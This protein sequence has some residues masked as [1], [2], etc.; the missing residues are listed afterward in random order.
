M[1]RSI[2]RRSIS[3]DFSFVILLV[4]SVF[5]V[6]PSGSWSIGVSY[7][8]PESGIDDSKETRKERLN[9]IYPGTKWCGSGNVAENSE[10]LGHFPVT[11]ACCRDHDQC[12]DVIEAMGTRH[13]ITN[14]A[15][16]TRVECSCDEK[17]YDCLHHSDDKIAPQIGTFYFSLLNTQCFRRDYPIISCKRYSTYPRR[18]VE[19]D[20]DESQPKIHQWFDVPPY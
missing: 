4:L 14:S 18:C 6:K 13:N 2:M 17:F 20:L 8:E 5:D 1:K 12:D 19:Y 15:F 11:D 9:L 7:P 10:D 16:Y 3:I